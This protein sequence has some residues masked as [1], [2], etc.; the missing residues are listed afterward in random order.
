MDNDLGCWLA[1]QC[2][3]WRWRGRD[4]LRLRSAKLIGGCHRR[5]H[6]DEQPGPDRCSPPGAFSCWRK[7]STSAPTDVLSIGPDHCR[8]LGP[9][10]RGA[11]CGVH[12]VLVPEPSYSVGHELN[13]A[14]TLILRRGGGPLDYGEL[15]ASGQAGTRSRKGKRLNPWCLSPIRSAIRWQMSR[16]GGAIGGS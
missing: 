2:C 9:R 15:D 5:Y 11:S 6:C 14:G 12:V 8:V 10:Q 16:R 3:A 13:A 1:S 7:A 4:L